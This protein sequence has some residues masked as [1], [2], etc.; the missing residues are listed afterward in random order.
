MARAG[1]MI[2]AYERTLIISTFFAFTIFLFILTV[3]TWKRKASS[4]K[5]AGYFS[6]GLAAAAIYTFGYS[7][8]LSSNTLSDVMF[9]VRFQ[10]LGIQLLTPFWLLF[11]LCITGH[12][13]IITRGRV[14]L[15]FLIPVFMIFATQTL[16]TLNLVHLNPRLI[17]IGPITSFTYDRGILIYIGLA[18]INVCMLASLILFT[19]MLIRSAT[20]FRSQAVLFWIGS[21]IPFVTEFHYNIGLSPYN[22]DTIPFALTISGLIFS[23]GLFRF[24]LLDIVPLA[25][26]VIFDSIKDGVIVLDNSNRIIDMNTSVQ[27]MLP[28]VSKTLI[29]KSINE[30]LTNFKTLADFAVGNDAGSIEIVKE[31]TG[32]S[33]NYLGTISSLHDSNHNQV[34]KIITLHDNTLARQLLDQLEELAARDSLTGI[35][36]R[37]SFDQLATQKMFNLQTPDSRMSLIM[38]DLDH[39]KN[40]N[41]TYGHSAGDLA[42][43][44][45]A[46]I[47]QKLLRQGDILGRYGGEEFVIFLPE[48]DL[49]SALVIAERLRSGIN[50]QEILYEEHSFTLSASLGVASCSQDSGRLTLDEFIQQADRAVYRAKQ[51]GRNQV[52][53]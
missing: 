14:I 53:S 48:T 47:C 7:M 51:A 28:G 13:Q 37:R 23:I 12:E 9:W 52:E 21:M 50:K 49:P 24:H 18:Y 44:T 22:I 2:M 27:N 4:G 3:I 15:L 29:G 19:I 45:I 1:E 5:A 42:L 11:T 26:D 40:I 32:G 20:T 25:R 10:H 46:S 38:F 35:Y 43:K 31:G 8:E 6:L 33:V 16:G 17:T 30:T 34:G 39:F 36:N 41:D